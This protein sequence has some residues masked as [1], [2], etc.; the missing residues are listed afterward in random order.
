M[1]LLPVDI[2]DDLAPR[3]A[4]LLNTDAL[5]FT[6]LEDVFESESY[7]QRF[8]F[9]FNIYQQQAEIFDSIF[10]S[11]IPAP[12]VNAGKYNNFRKQVFNL[13]NTV[14]CARAK[15]H[16]EET[17]KQKIWKQVDLLDDFYLQLS[18]NG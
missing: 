9:R 4:A 3:Y 10:T 15:N 13:I 6:H 11:H 12:A 17:E 8:D 2:N 1:E 18:N 5:I 14:K 16:F 7:A